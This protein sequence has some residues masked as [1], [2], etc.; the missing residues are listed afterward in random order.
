MLRKI[1]ASSLLIC[2]PSAYSAITSSEPDF[3]SNLR[4]N[5]VAQVV[6][7]LENRELCRYSGRVIFGGGNRRTTNLYSMSANLNITSGVCQNPEQFFIPTTLCYDNK[8]SADTPLTKFS[9]PITH[10][11]NTANLLGTLYMWVPAKQQGY[12][13]AMEMI[14]NKE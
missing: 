9:G 2:I 10:G 7:K 6:L 14:L 1:I 3:C 8:L 12:I 11:G 13:T 5:W 4:G